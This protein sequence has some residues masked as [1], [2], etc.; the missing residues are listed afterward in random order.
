V[1][2][3]DRGFINTMAN[4]PL[5]SEEDNSIEPKIIQP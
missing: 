4:I 3:V 1:I 5:D 2:R